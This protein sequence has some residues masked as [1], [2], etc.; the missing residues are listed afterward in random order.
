M[1]GETVWTYTKF[2]NGNVLYFTYT[3]TPRGPRSRATK[4]K[5]HDNCVHDGI[6]LTYVRGGEAGVLRGVV[7]VHEA[8]PEF[9]AQVDMHEWPQTTFYQLFVQIN[10]GFGRPGAVVVRLTFD[11]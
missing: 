4:Y 11:A 1:I 6:I 3:P 8:I 10:D 9:G 7:N 5:L 2:M